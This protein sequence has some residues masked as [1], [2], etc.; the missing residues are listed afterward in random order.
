MPKKHFYL[1][2]SIAFGIARGL[3]SLRYS[4]TVKGEKEI[5]EK[6]GS[7]RGVLFLPNHP[8]EIDPILLMAYL[9]PKYFPRPMVVEHFYRLKGFQWI[10]DLIGAMP[11]PTMEEKANI[12]RGK[13]IA[14]IFNDVL[15]SIEAGDNFVIYP[16]GKLKASGKE[17]LGGASFV[18][19]LLQTSS[20]I[21]VVLIRTTGL[22]GS[23]FSRAHTGKSPDFGKT[24]LT[25]FFK[26]LK[27]GI[28]FSPR[29]KVL[30]EIALAPKELPVKSSRLSLISI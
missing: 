20:E 8:A 11:I 24:L 22:W 16:A 26:L 3:L 29:R 30:L 18:H 6:L 7:N 19:S 13:E 23:S 4:V 12:W 9:G 15:R 2:R 27:N 10:L 25:N 1:L 28:F 21:D 17:L 5:A 14:K